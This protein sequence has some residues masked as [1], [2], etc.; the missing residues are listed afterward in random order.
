MVKF[1]FGPV[2]LAVLL[3]SSTAWADISPPECT[4]EEY[5]YGGQVC[6]SCE[7]SHEN[8]DACEERYA[9]TSFDFECTTGE[10]ALW[11]EVWCSSAAEL[12]AA[13]AAAAESERCSVQEISVGGLTCESCDASYQVPAICSQHYANT[14]YTF[15]CTTGGRTFWTEVWCTGSAANT[16][17]ETGGCH[18]GAK[19]VPLQAWLA[20]LPLL[21]LVFLRLR[22]HFQLRG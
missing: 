17:S 6:E 11:T 16:G 19:G 9:G 7:A 4:V 2:V 20:F 1:V 10:W 12:E 15:A 3:V 8:R 18:G 5:S 21:G 13:E 14:D 22:R